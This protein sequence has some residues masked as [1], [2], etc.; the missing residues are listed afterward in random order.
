M[1]ISLFVALLGLVSGPQSLASVHTPTAILIDKKTNQLYVSE[2]RDE[3]YSIL[4]TYHATLGQVKGDKEAEDDLKTPEGIYLFKSVSSPPSLQKKFGAMGFYMNFPNAFD[5]LA[6]R[7]GSAIM[8]HATDEPDRLKN[9]YDSKGCIVVRNEEISEIKPFIRLGLTPILVFAE[10][11]Q[12]YLH[13]SQ[14]APL[15]NFFK[16]W[17]QNWEKKDLERYI[18]HY[19]TDFV[20]NGKNKS[21]WKIYKNHL[22]SIYS[23]IEVDPEN[24]LFFRHPKYT[25][26]T[27]TQ[28]YRSKMKRGGWGH[29][30]RGTKILFVAEES[31]EPKIIA[32]NFSQLMW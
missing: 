6:G 25:M 3:G 32:E 9:N 26:I 1:I 18:E 12:E 8:L 2:Y 11:T 27:F 22:N 24:V 29:R 5:Q 10:L 15:R 30:S 7:T 16:S 21:E 28:N 31:G 13:F 14:D 17:I 19:H 20:A 4:K 23:T